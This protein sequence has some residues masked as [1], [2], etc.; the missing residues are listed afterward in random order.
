MNKQDILLLLLAALLIC[1]AILTIFLGGKGDSRHG[2]G[3]FL[4]RHQSGRSLTASSPPP[5]IV[6]REGAG[7]YRFTVTCGLTGID[8]AGLG[9]SGTAR[10]N[11]G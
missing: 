5:V 11:S 8:A 4:G 2:Y 3:L 1:A 6:H 9:R 7:I 10:I